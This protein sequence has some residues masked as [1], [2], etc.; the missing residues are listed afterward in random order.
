VSVTMGY[1]KQ[2][3]RSAMRLD[4]LYARWASIERKIN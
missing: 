1:S 3:V 2:R 4:Y